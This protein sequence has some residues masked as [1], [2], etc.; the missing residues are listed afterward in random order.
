MVIRAI[1]FDDSRLLDTWDRAAALDRPWRELAVLE[2]ATDVTLDELARLPI[3]ERDRLLLT[4]R[5]GAFGSALNCETTC[6]SCGTRLE[7]SMDAR[8]L[9]VPARV[10]HP[11]DFVLSDDAVTVRF[12]LPDSTDIAECRTDAGVARG[13]AYVLADRCIEVLAVADD[14]ARPV[15]ISDRLRDHVAE[16]MAALDAQA[17][18]VFAL[19]CVACDHRWQSP[20]DPAAFL[21]SEVDAHAAR[22]TLEVHQLARAYG[23]HEASILAMGATRR[24]RYLALLLQ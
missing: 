15:A 23:W 10:A 6:P 18:V 11:S 7:M 14:A 24:R 13:A 1:A 17:D 12:R 5:I 8:D 22:L 2:I 9:L 19:H 16:R 4:L 3:G 21:L 20:F